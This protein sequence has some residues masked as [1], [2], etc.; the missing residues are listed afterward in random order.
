[1]SNLPQSPVTPT[2]RIS[3][4]I[5]ADAALFR[6]HY[7]SPVLIWHPP[8]LPFFS[9]AFY[10]L[11]KLF[12]NTLS[13]FPYCLEIR[14]H[15]PQNKCHAWLDVLPTFL[16]FCH[17][18]QSTWMTC[19]SLSTSFPLQVLL[20]LKEC[21]SLIFCYLN[22]LHHLPCLRIMS[23]SLWNF[24]ESHRCNFS[25]V[26]LSYFVFNSI[27]PFPLPCLSLPL[28]YEFPGWKNQVSLITL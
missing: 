1:M 25:S 8:T 12:P 14:I 13:L 5:L 3:S 19:D 23:H 26:L 17:S 22:I 11:L 15:L 7:F 28:T 10:R 16:A 21:L 9:E 18:P 2:S 27:L 20:S 4:T 6:I 24:P